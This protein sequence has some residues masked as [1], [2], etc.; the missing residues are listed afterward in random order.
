MLQHQVGDMQI[1]RIVEYQSWEY[2]RTSFFPQTTLEDWVRH[3]S[4]M[5]PY[6]M[7]PETGIGP[8]TS[9]P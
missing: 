4:W 6:A 5:K 8:R 1:T 9:R 7:D 3:E 2:E